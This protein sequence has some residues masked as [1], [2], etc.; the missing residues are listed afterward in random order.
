MSQRLPRLT[1]GDLRRAGWAEHSQVG[2]HRQL[3]HP[4]RPGRVTVPIHAGEMVGPEL[5]KRILRQAGLTAGELR[6]L[7]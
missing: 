6:T 4:I 5:L 1:V 2:S 7:L 3:K